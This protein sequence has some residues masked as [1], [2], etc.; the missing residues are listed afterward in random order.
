MVDVKITR[1]AFVT[2][3]GEASEMARRRR[4][5]PKLVVSSGKFV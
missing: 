3:G 4:L 2:L 1:E 5:A